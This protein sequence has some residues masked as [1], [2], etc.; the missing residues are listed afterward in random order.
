MLFFHRHAATPF[1]GIFHGSQFVFTDVSYIHLGRTAEVTRG[2]V[3]A[4]IA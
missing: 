1:A 4:R 2:F 3:S